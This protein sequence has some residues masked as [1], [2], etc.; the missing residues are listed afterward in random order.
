MKVKESKE[1]KGFHQ[2][3]KAVWKK[4]GVWTWTLRMRSRVAKSW[5]SKGGNCSRSCEMLNSSRVCRKSFRKTSRVTCSI[6]C[7][8]WTRLHARTQE[9]IEKIA[10][11][12]KHPGQNKKCAE[13]QYRSRRGDAEAPRGAQAKRGAYFFLSNKVNKNKMADAEMT[14]ELQRLQAGEERRGS[15]ASQTGDCC[16]EALWQQIIA[17]WTHRVEAAM[18][19]KLVT[20]VWRPCGS[21]LSLSGRIESR[22]CSKGTEK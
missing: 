16:L 4:S 21:R 12:T 9:S 10:K 6:S 8:R 17:F 5:M 20:V 19:R 13:R 22:L 3:E 11:D 2:G 15:N 1:G 7:K 14:A 18:P